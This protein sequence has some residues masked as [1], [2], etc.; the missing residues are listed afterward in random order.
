MLEVAM[1]SLQL[2]EDKRNTVDEGDQVGATVVWVTV[3]PKLRNKEELVV[4]RVL[5]VDD[6]KSVDCLA[7][8][9]LTNTDRNTL[10]EKFV[11]LAISAHALQGPA[12]LCDFFH[13]LIDRLR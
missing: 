1:C 7:A 5:P 9:R 4:L 12:I 10:A 13:S 8:V 3:D 6:I 2:D 11:H